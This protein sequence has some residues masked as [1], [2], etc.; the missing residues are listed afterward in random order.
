M[1][2]GYECFG[3][4]ESVVCGGEIETCYIRC[5]CTTYEFPQNE[6]FL[7]EKSGRS[8]VLGGAS[9]L[10]GG[11]SAG[12]RGQ[13]KYAQD[14]GAAAED[15][16]GAGLADGSE[17]RRGANYLREQLAAGPDIRTELKLREALAEN[18]LRAGDS[19]GAVEQLETIRSECKEKGIVLK[20]GF[21][22]DLRETLA[23]AYL[24]LGEQENCVMNHGQSSCVFPIRMKAVHTVTR[25]IGRGDSG[26]NRAA[27]SGPD[28]LREGDLKLTPVERKAFTY[29]HL[30]E[31]KH[32]HS[33]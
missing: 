30:P 31:V 1:A 27:G 8:G 4:G 23:I 33:L 7:G 12:E 18:L 5:G 13:W 17:Q 15:L 24:Q 32:Q 16:R 10:G 29:K 28:R 14:G 22:H 2:S 26:A 3:D 19:A 6:N 9:V 25:G 11:A 21:E 20:A